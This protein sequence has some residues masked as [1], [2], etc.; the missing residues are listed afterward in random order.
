RQGLHGLV[1][2]LGLLG[3]FLGHAGGGGHLLG[4]LAYRRAQFFGGGG[5]RLDVGGRLFR[6]RC[7]AGGLRR[8]FIGHGAQGFGGHFQFLGGGGGGAGHFLNVFRQPDFFRGHPPGD[9]GG[10]VLAVAVV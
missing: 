5:H 4:N 8:R 3:R 6:R 10:D 9:H 1:G 2:D 7:H